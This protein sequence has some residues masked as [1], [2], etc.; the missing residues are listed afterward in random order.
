MRVEFLKP[1]TVAG[2]SYR[3]GEI[4]E[5]DDAQAKNLVST[6]VVREFKVAG[7]KDDDG[8]EPDEKR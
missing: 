4:A 1:Q 5:I 7:E 3:V 6:G 2:R 8:E